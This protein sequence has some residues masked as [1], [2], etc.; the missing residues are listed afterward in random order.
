MFPAVNIYELTLDYAVDCHFTEVHELRV[1]TERVFGV[2][3]KVLPDLRLAST[4]E[5]GGIAVYT[6]ARFVDFND[7]YFSRAI[8]LLGKSAGHV[9]V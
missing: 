6:T 7:G 9:V 8:G 5:K 4:M 1:W 3:E 2:A